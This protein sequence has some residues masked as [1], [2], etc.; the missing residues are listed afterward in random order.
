MFSSDFRFYLSTPSPFLAVIEK[1]T[2][3][4]GGSERVE[5][6]TQGLDVATGKPDLLGLSRLGRP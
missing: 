2:K 5:E 3:H 1:E 6:T 4:H